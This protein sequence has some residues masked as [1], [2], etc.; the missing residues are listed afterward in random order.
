MSRIGD[1][2]RAVADR[3]A[4][5]GARGTAPLAFD[6]AARQQAIDPVRL[7]A[8]RLARLRDQLVRH[9]YGAALLSDPINIRYATGSR[10]MAVWTMHAP[11][12]YAFVPVDGPVVL[13]EFATSKHVS[14][15]L[16]TVDELR[17]GTCAFY[18]LAGPRTAEMAER[19]AREIA[20]LT[21]AHAGD[22]RLA[23]D[24]CEPW[25]ARHL[26]ASG[27]TLFDAQAPA[28]LARMIKTPEELDCMQLSMDVCDVA[29]QRMRDALQPGVTE[30]QLWAVLHETNVA[31]D[32]EWIECRLLASGPRTN[33][34]FQECG[35]RVIEPGDLVGFD[36]DMVGPSGY[37]AD[38]SRTFLCPGRAPT[39]EQR[40]LYEIAQEQILTNVSVLQP[41]M[42][43][44]E[45]SQRCWPVPDQYL[46]NR[47]M[48]MVHGAG[49]VDEAPAIAYAVDFPAW[50]Y[51]GV[52]EEDMVLCVESFIGEDGGREG[53]KLEEQVVITSAGATI[54]S[55]S[56]LVDALTQ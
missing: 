51:D 12:R 39:A 36:T 38:I 13:F 5:S 22:R 25:L 11:G 48:L 18:F 8:G 1:A 45:F 17:D 40:R 29:V 56:P 26:E 6:V 50:G 47:Y 4:G 49:M 15:G 53:V 3:R 21:H 23:V 41:G 52:I 7:R 42:S 14:R 37:L 10:N 16:E 34:W 20:A 55:R 46:P 19:W 54:M 35:H 28:E 30:N 32:G 43:L 33:P 9:D 27:I 44:R 31:H 24:R 2:M